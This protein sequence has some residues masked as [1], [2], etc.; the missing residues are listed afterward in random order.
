MF[1][2]YRITQRTFWNDFVCPRPK[3]AF[4][5]IGDVVHFYIVGASWGSKTSICHQGRAFL[6]RLVPKLPPVLRTF[7]LT[8]WAGRM[9]PWKS[10][11]PPGPCSEDPAGDLGSDLKQDALRYGVLRSRSRRPA[12]SPDQVFNIV[13]HLRV[14]SRD[15]DEHTIHRQ[16]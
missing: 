13:Q 7:F 8:Q 10:P 15:F 9:R 11:A 12:T 16:Y 6:M 2:G 4:E 1:L 14:H 3:S 5:C